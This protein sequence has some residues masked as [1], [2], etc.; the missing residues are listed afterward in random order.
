MQI[1]KGTKLGGTLRGGLRRRSNTVKARSETGSE[2]RGLLA[3]ASRSA[4]WSVVLVADEVTKKVFFHV[5]C[6][7]PIGTA[8]EI[9]PVTETDNWG[10]I[11]KSLRNYL[12]IIP[13]GS[14]KEQ[15]D[16]LKARFG[17][18]NSTPMIGTKRPGFTET[19]QGYV[20][21]V[22]MIGDAVGTCFWLGK[23]DNTAPGVWAGSAEE[24]R[25]ATSLLRYS[26]FAT[27]AFLAMLASPAREYL[28]RCGA[29]GAGSFISETATFNFVGDSGSGKSLVGRIAASA[30]GHPDAR[31]KWDF[32]R[33]GVEK[34]LNSR[35]QLGAIFDDTEKFI[36]DDRDLRKA[37]ATVT[38]YVADG[39]SKELSENLDKNGI[40]P[41]N[42]DTFAA[43]SS[44]KPIAEL[45]GSA[46]AAAL[47]KG[48]QVRFYEMRIPDPN[49]GG[50]FDQPPP[51]VDRVEFAMK[52]SR[53]IEIIIEQNYGLFFPAWIELLLGRNYAGRIVELIEW[54]VDE[55]KKLTTSGTWDGYRERFARKFGLL[56]AIGVLITE[57]KLISWPKEWA[58]TAVSRCYA[59][60]L[61]TANESNARKQFDAPGQALETP[62]QAFTRLMRSYTEGRFLSVPPSKGRAIVID[63][64]K[65]GILTLYKNRRCLG[66]SNEALITFCGSGLRADEFFQLLKAKGLYKRGHGNV[67]TTEMTIPMVI[68]GVLKNTPRFLLLDFEKFKT[69]VKAADELGEV[70]RSEIDRML[71]P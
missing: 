16:F 24:Y 3:S 28:R 69:M 13:G 52:T 45:L 30:A 61:A 21:G 6:P 8:R 47:T 50:I 15:I 60:A 34:Y 14:E 27:V 65:L 4:E 38:Q 26:S 49:E 56:F 18:V 20:C 25:K 59:N 2:S 33:P 11:H 10:K 57:N 53:Q 29:P 5:E 62:E 12:A 67:R 63:D 70:T 32:S 43:S 71:D 46:S 51:G 19:G 39:H 7:T 31:S 40:V 48:T 58:F 54:F 68:Q 37:I 35:N 9:F 66:I 44:P 1:K 41:L 64:D 23:T 42:W 17:S 22:K 36:G 55:M